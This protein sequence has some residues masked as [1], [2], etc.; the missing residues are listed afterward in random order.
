MSEVPVASMSDADV[1]PVFAEPVEFLDGVKLAA[2]CV[3]GAF[4]DIL[5]C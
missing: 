4:S 2:F 5:Y 1:I 3:S